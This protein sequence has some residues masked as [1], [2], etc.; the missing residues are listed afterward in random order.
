LLVSCEETRVSSTKE[1]TAAPGSVS[2]SPERRSSPVRPQEQFRATWTMLPPPR[3]IR[4]SAAFG[5]TGD[6]LIVWG[7]YVYTGYGGESSESDGFAFDARTRAWRDIAASP[8][9]PRT[10]PAAAWTGSELLVWGGSTTPSIEGFL[11]DGAAYDP[12]VDAWRMVPPAPVSARAPLSVWT[13][14]E[15]IVW[16][17]SVRVDERPRD[18]AAYD[19]ATNTWRSITDAPIELT[20][21]TASWTGREMIVFGAALHGGNK[22]ESKNAIA[23]AYDPA[24][25]EWRRL[26]VSRLSPQASTSSWNGRELIAW[27]YEHASA[28]YDPRTNEWRDLPRVPLDFAECV[29]ESVRMGPDVFGEYCGSM[30][31]FDRSDDEWRDV[32]RRPYRGW[33]FTLVGAGRVALLFGRRIGTKEKG[34]LLYRP[35]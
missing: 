20:D 9:S 21:A 28:A 1:G 29:P 13:G 33:G 3:E 35:E 2:R 22:P 27:D 10:V 14:S 32:T 26:P 4:T 7:G 6:Q 12:A 15:L 17:T 34:M 16:G 5:W 31:V 8:L 11:A 25:D 24:R 19:P 18:G 30:A 23:A